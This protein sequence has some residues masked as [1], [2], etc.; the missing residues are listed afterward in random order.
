MT[1]WSQRQRDV[2][3]E[4][5][6]I[7]YICFD[8]HQPDSDGFGLDL[9][10]RTR[11]FYRPV[12]QKKSPFDGLSFGGPPIREQIPLSSKGTRVAHAKLTL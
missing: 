10:E 12:V 11:A 4:R 9:R 1:T 8:S 5:T 2:F 7:S 6:D 3:T